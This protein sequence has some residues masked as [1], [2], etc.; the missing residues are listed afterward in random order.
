MAQFRFEDLEI[1]K[2]AIQISMKLFD[3]ADRLEE[4]KLYRFAEQL[5][6]AGLSLT[7]NIAEGSGSFTNLDFSNFLKFSRRSVFECANMIYVFRLKYLI[8]EQEKTELWNN[9]EILSKSLANFKKTL[10]K[11]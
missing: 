4:H 8:S 2:M 3:I 9:L 11:S 7:N 10:L 1:W 6:G 5:R